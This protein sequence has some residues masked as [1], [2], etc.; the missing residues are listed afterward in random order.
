[1]VTA[2]TVTFLQMK[3]QG[4]NPRTM[5]TH[6]LIACGL[7]AYRFRPLSD[8]Q[9]A[10]PLIARWL[11]GYRG[12]Q[13]PM[14]YVPRPKESDASSERTKRLVRRNR[15]QRVICIG[16]HV[17]RYQTRTIIQYSDIIVKYSGI[18]VKYSVIISKYF[19]I[20]HSCLRRESCI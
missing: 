5:C 15:T 19:R 7:C 2:V 17:R 10:L 20:N 1:M 12:S 4:Q 16:A 13:V 9:A 18:I 14:I 6:A 3:I 11:L 8:K